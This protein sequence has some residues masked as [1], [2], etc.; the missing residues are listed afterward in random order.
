VLV[1]QPHQLALD[2]ADQ[3]HPDDVHRLR[4]GDPQ[5]AAELRLD[6]QLVE[7]PR[8]LRAAAVHDHRLEAGEAQERHVLGERTLEHRVG[9]GVAAV[10]D[11]HDLAVV[12]LEPRQRSGQDVGLG[13]VGVGLGHEL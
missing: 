12:G 13:P 2:L 8:D 4:R 6:P 11:D 3:H 5:P 1:D 10:L 7:H 9:H